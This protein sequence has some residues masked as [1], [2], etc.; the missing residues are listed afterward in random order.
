MNVLFTTSTKVPT[1][2]LM[3]ATKN[4]RK[5]KDKHFCLHIWERPRL[6][7]YKKRRESQDFCSWQ[8]PKKRKKEK[9]PTFLLMGAKKGGKNINIVAPD[10]KKGKKRESHHFCSWQKKEKVPTFLVGTTT[11]MKTFEWKFW[12][13]TMNMGKETTTIFFTQNNI[14]RRKRGKVWRVGRHLLLSGPH[15]VPIYP[16]FGYHHPP[17]MPR[18]LFTGSP[19]MT[20]SFRGVPRSPPLPCHNVIYQP[21]FNSIRPGG[22]GRGGVRNHF[23]WSKNI[24]FGRGITKLVRNALFS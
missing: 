6:N 5:R 22:R 14:Y 8:Q 16:P 23:S 11:N 19:I 2:L 21:P 18:H 9:V 3:T 20:S 17:T 1:S 15:L 4:A 7:I 24:R 13:I 12:L 10:S